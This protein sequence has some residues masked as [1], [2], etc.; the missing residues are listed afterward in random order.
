MIGFIQSKTSL[1]ND[2]EGCEGE[3]EGG[4]SMITQINLYTM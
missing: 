1:V 3:G 2:L 4:K